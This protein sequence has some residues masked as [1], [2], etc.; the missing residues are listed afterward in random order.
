M[1]RHTTVSDIPHLY[2][3][4]LE[5]GHNGQNAADY[6]NDPYLLGHFYAAPYALY[7]NEYSFVYVDEKTGLPAGYI[8][9]T[10]DSFTF[11]LRR[12]E[13]LKPLESYCKNNKNNKSEEEAGIKSTIIDELK[14][15]KLKEAKPTDEG[16]WCN[17]Y[18]AH[19]HIDILAEHQ[20][21]G[22]GHKLMQTFLDNLRANN[23]T[24]V[25]L[26]VSKENHGAC[27]FYEKEGFSVLYQA[28]WGFW[29]GKKL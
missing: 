20:G 21:K 26:G 23:V 5:T 9:G 13:F 14:R 18:P 2:K 29:L 22:L 6:F 11:N 28:E 25:H 27:K 24:G 3:I 7:A 17:D 1:I 4:C 15:N 10:D 8:L 16:F 12:N 19:L